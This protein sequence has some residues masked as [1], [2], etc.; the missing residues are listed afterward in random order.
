MSSRISIKFI[1]KYIKYWE[2][3]LEKTEKETIKMVEENEKAK[4]LVY[5][6]ADQYLREENLRGRIRAGYCILNNCRR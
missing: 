3:E 2:E 5:E 1:K 6:M 4:Q